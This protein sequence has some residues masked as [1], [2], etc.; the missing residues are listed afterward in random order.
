MCL[1]FDLDNLPQTLAEI[2]QLQK[3]LKQVN[4]WGLG[5]NLALLG[6]RFASAKF[7]AKPNII[8]FFYYES[9]SCL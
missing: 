1:L 5:A 7:V 3:D 8:C 2:D 9:F 6:L 4:G